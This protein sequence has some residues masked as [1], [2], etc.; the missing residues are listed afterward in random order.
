MIHISTGNK[1]DVV[2][3]YEDGRQVIKGLKPHGCDLIPVRDPAGLAS[4]L[5][6]LIDECRRYNDGFTIRGES[7]GKKD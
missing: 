6:R 7:Y 2:Y 4:V 3:D 5:L 1:L